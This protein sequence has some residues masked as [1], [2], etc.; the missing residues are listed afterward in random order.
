MS[1]NA[2]AWRRW[3][4]LVF[5]GIAFAMLVWGQTVLQPK[6]DGVAFI[7]YWLGC[8][9]FTVLAMMTALL[10]I[11]LIRRKQRRDRRELVR[12]TFS[13]AEEAEDENDPENHSTEGK[14]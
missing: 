4:G 13:N 6:P 10:D 8:F 2:Q 14:M 7:L 5:L 3:F 12:R 11:W 1:N 9:V